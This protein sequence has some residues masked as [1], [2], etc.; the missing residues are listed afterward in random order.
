[1]RVLRKKEMVPHPLAGPVLSGLWCE[2]P[3]GAGVLGVQ[4]VGQRIKA[5]GRQVSTLRAE[6]P[7]RWGPAWG[8]LGTWGCSEVGLKVER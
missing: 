3:P 1:M 6:V 2:R 5:K 8:G 4:L 7:S